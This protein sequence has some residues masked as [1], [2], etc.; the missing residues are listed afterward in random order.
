[1]EVSRVG[2]GAA[3]HGRSDVSDGHVERVLN[4]A[5]D[6]GINFIDTAPSYGSSEER[7]VPSRSCSW[8]DGLMALYYIL[9]YN[10]F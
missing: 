2:L 6:L 3:Q 9:R 1:M 10:I 4:L 7:Q 8:K 5:L